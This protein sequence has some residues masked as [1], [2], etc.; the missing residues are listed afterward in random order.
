M[1]DSLDDLHN[2]NEPK[3][4]KLLFLTDA[5]FEEWLKQAGLLYRQRYCDK[6]YSAMALK[7]R[8]G[9]NYP[10][11]QCNKRNMGKK[12]YREIGYLVGTWF[13]GSHL[14]LKNIFQLSFYFCRQTHTQEL[15]QID[16]E[17][18]TVRASAE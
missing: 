11:W 2:F 5:E 12:C 16:M 13:E 8:S 7:F 9:E 14:S 1:M 4:Y 6:C 17:K 10:T 18:A 3:L 15:M